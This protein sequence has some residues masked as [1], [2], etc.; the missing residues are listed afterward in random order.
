MNKLWPN[1]YL[2]FLKRF[3]HF[4]CEKKLTYRSQ[5][6][7]QSVAESC[8]ELSAVINTID[9][10]IRLADVY[11]RRYRDGQLSSVSQSRVSNNERSISTTK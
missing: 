3:F 4:F 8:R 1:F 2:T 6:V 5:V 11:R 10:A 9:L 7:L